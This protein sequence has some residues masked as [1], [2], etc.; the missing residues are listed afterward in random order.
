MYLVDFIKKEN[1]WEKFVKKQKYTSFVQSSNYGK[2]YK[3]LGEDYWILGIFDEQKTLVGGSIILST[4]AKRGNFFYLPYG[5]ILEYNN[6]L[7]KKT[8]FVELSKF[9]REKKMDFIR[10]SPLIL[11][12]EEGRG[13]IQKFGYRPAPMHVLAENSWLLDLSK[14]EQILLLGMKKNH[15]NLIRRCEREGV[16]IE[17][18][19]DK[20]SIDILH[21]MLD[22]TE[23]RHN[24]IRFSREYIN[25]EFKKFFEAG[26]AT[27]FV[28]YLPDGRPDSATIIIFYGTMAVYRHSAS[29]NIEKRLPTSYL[30]QW[31]IIQEAK[32]RGMKWYNFWGVDPIGAKDSHPFAGIGHFKRGFGGFQE[33]LLHCHD[34]PITKR[35]WI[36]WTIEMIRKKRRGF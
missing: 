18:K 33:S 6:E 23:K 25:A 24:F 26:E 16:R 22:I 9:A 7:I 2:F 32:K 30:M 28:G 17:Q 3:N 27:I 4:H 13:A 1:I 35:Y 14:D 12:T 19:V 10:I 8:F 29:L 11:D 21:H 5:P 36:N 34:L 20:K 15:R 31:K